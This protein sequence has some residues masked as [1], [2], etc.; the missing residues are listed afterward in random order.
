MRLGS[1]DGRACGFQAFT[2]PSEEAETTVSESVSVANPA[3]RNDTGLFG[4]S[5]IG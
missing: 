3:V 4:Y 2:D 1:E 5:Y